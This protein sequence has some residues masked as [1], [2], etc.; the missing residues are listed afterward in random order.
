MPLPMS[1]NPQLD[2][3]L[4]AFPAAVNTNEYTYIGGIKDVNPGWYK[5]GLATDPVEERLDIEVEYGKFIFFEPFEFIIL[6]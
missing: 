6:G 2:F 5:V 1:A 4:T 3:S